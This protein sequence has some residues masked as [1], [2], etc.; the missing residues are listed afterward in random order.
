MKNGFVGED[1]FTSSTFGK[2][3]SLRVDGGVNAVSI[4][5]SGRDVV[6]ASK[7]GLLI[8]DLDDPFQPPRLL[9]HLTSW[10]V[11]DVQWS[12]HKSKPYWVISTSNQKAMV[13]N[14]AR[15]STDAIEH[16]LHG[17]SR[18][19]TDINFHPDHPEIL[20][21]CSIDTTVLAWD[22][23]SPQ[24]PY[25]KT[26]DWR[27]GASQVKWST[28]DSNLIAS[29]HGNYV[30]MWDV[31]KG[32]TPLFQMHGHTS[33]VNNISFDPSSKNRIMT[34]SNDGTVQYWDYTAAC[35]TPT[36]TV[37]TDFPVGRGRFLP[38]GDGSCVIPMIEGGNNIYLMNH[39]F[40]ETDDKEVKLQPIYVFKGHKDRVTDF[41]WRSR[42]S[43]NS[44]TDDREF[45][46][47]SWSND[48]DLRLWPIP[49][50]V[51]EKVNF[52]RKQKLPSPLP[53]FSYHSY[54]EEPIQYRDKEEF[55]KIIGT[56]ASYRYPKE[57]FVSTVPGGRNTNE[58]D[59]I[60]HLAWL[61]G[62]RVNNDDDNGGQV[63][64]TLLYS[65]NGYSLASAEYRNLGEEFSG[66]GHKFSKLNFEKIS[67]STGELVITL[68]RPSNKE[69]LVF[70][71]VEAD[72]PQGYPRKGRYPK[73]HI[74]ENR[75]F[76]KETR[77][78]LETTLSD[79]AIK[80]TNK[81]K[82]CLEPCLRF[83]L[84]ENVDLTILDEEDEGLVDFD[85][86]KKLGLDDDFG[87][88]ENTRNMSDSDGSIDS[89]THFEQDFETTAELGGKNN[90][91][92]FETLGGQDFDSTPVPKGCGAV[93]TAQGQL[94]CFFASS[95][96]SEKQQKVKEKLFKFS[97]NGVRSFGKLKS[98][99]KNSDKRITS[100]SD[101]T[102][103]RPKTY[104][105]TL[106]QPDENDEKTLDSSSGSDFD[107][108]DSLEDESSEEDDFDDILNN[109]ITFRKKIPIISMRANSV[110]EAYSEGEK[111]A[112][113]S[114]VGKNIVCVRDFSHVIPDSLNLAL[115]YRLMGEEPEVLCKYNASVAESFGFSDIST[116]WKIISDMLISQSKDIFNHQDWCFDQYGGQVFIKQIIAYFE[117]TKNIQMLAMLACLLV[118]P[119]I[120]EELQTKV[121]SDM[122]ESIISY[123]ND[124]R[125]FSSSRSTP[126]GYA[127]SIHLQNA[128][129]DGSSVRS[130]NYFNHKEPMLRSQSTSRH[131]S[132]ARSSLEEPNANYF[133]Q[134]DD[135]HNILPDVKVEVLATE[136]SDLS[137]GSSASLLDPRDEEKLRSFR[138][139]YAEL[140]YLWGLPVHR[141]KILK[142]NINHNTELG[143]I[144]SLKTSETSDIYK[145]VDSRFVS[146]FQ[147]VGQ[148]AAYTYAEIHNCCFCSTPVKRRLFV[149]NLC[150]H[151]MHARCSNQWWKEESECPTGCGCRCVSFE[152]TGEE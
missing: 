106:Q 42:H 54:R 135:V 14:L 84:G 28:N 152:E 40:F 3:L 103:P 37:I 114:K 146:P 21:T 15:S 139:Q 31:R 72:F 23:R 136:I 117:L 4:N 45:Q 73:F 66:V 61:S 98:S 9:R 26:A 51:Y 69:Q 133:N 91:N 94:L 134:F 2:S 110:S 49:D 111:T 24:A 149:C 142:F 107:T 87:L 65:D 79:I 88:S 126:M 104:L 80:Y 113:S 128:H 97:A 120:S 137:N 50:I 11:A 78:E 43:E 16:V 17:H 115:N 55:T 74:E 143:F 64:N 19:I 36:K 122:V 124:S 33:S 96:K 63:A 100:T 18:A 121:N 140:L 1:P 46:L 89:G 102:K 119:G 30:S 38:F 147:S 10:Q 76:T 148:H 34:S 109:D 68:N 123:E 145:G 48:S 112:E 93:W 138:L 125:N 83:L 90:K 86:M 57:H 32:T 67:V 53:D 58:A 29:S 52:S 22:M 118:T 27:A 6:L 151:I 71:R 44:L 129:F 35:A 59:R 95:S 82:Y 12:P 132:M 56:D 39:E 144:N 101:K 116:C 131:T 81:E 20:A 141:V 150:Q 85:I 41:L 8:V 7:Q 108:D 99:N 70:L 130:E 5:P 60:D 77:T 47:V 25:Y 105:E 13:W 127:S 75:E 62:V 92:H